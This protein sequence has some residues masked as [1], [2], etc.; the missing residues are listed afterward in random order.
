MPKETPV[1]LKDSKDVQHVLVQ[2]DLKKGK[3]MVI[4]NFTAWENIA[5]L[6]E[7]LGVTAE[8]CLQEGIPKK[9]VYQAITDYLMKVLGNYKIVNQSA[10]KEHPLLPKK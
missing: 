2:V 9:E 1:V 4:S 10:V 6:I 3:T 8:K 5:H 7:G